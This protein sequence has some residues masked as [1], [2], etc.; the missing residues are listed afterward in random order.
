MYSLL[1]KNPNPSNYMIIFSTRLILLFISILFLSCISI[2]SLYSQKSIRDSTINLVMIDISYGGYL[3]QGDLG[4]RFGYTSLL[5]GNVGFKFKSNLYLS[6]GGYF[7][8]GDNIKENQIL[9]GV[10]HY[11]MFTDGRS[12]AVDAGWIDRDGQVIVPSLAQRG[13]TIPFRV[14]K[15]FNKISFKKTNP[16]TGLFI[17]TG[18]QFMQHHIS[19]SAPVNVPYITG[20]Y[21]KGYDRLTQGIGVLGSVG[22]RYFGSSRFINFFFAFDYQYN[23]TQNRRFDFDLQRQDTRTRSD[24]LTGFRFGWTIPLYKEAPEGYYYY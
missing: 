14:G 4:K 23:F 3:P 7:L 2:N 20:D 12:T 24:I 10:S 16:N 1:H 22:Y 19:I 13:F 5:G 9:K 18:A 8:F 15:I 6:L 21:E 11:N 17:E